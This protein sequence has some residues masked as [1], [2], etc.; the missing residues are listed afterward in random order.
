[1]TNDFRARCLRLS[2][3]LELEDYELAQ[4]DLTVLAAL[5]Q[6]RPGRAVAW[7]KEVAKELKAKGVL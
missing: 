6:G 2:R 3:L 7:L 1:M 5:T 4:R